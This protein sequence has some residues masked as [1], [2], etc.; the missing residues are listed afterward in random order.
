MQNGPI[1]A[2]KQ[3]VV[4]NTSHLVAALSNLPDMIQNIGG[5]TATDAA[6]AAADAAADAVKAAADADAAAD[7]V[8][9]AVNNP[10]FTA[11]AKEML[12][13]ENAQDILSGLLE[14]GNDAVEALCETASDNPI[15]AGLTVAAG[16]ATL[17]GLWYRKHLQNKA[18]AAKKDNRDEKPAGGNDSSL[19]AANTGASSSSA[20]PITEEDTAQPRRSPSNSPKLNRRGSGGHNSD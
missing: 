1:A 9:A 5:D 19:D 7:A 17:G 12:T 11:A 14:M 4:D 3:M 13:I 20:S 16:A 6:K 18:A 8:N 10:E 2:I 15:A